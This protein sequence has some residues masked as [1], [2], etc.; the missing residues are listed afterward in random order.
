MTA[1]LY[2]FVSSKMQELAAER[3]AAATRGV[4]G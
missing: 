4:P 1:P 2:V 3:Q